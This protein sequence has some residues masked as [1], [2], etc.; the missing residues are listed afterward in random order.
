MYV[1]VEI[2]VIKIKIKEYTF[3]DIVMNQL[4]KQNGLLGNKNIKSIKKKKMFG[5]GN[6]KIQQFGG[7]SKW[8]Y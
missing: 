1:N 5:A 6:M 3:V 2:T 4:I 7:R 8:V